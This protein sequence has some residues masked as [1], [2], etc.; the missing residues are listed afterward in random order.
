MKIKGRLWIFPDDNIS[1]DQIFPGKYTYQPLTNEEMAKYSM[2]DYLPEFTKEVQKGDII[3]AGKNFGCGS[4]REQAVT[5]LKFSGVGAIIAPSFARIYYRNAIN[6]AL[7]AIESNEAVTYALEN[8]DK[9][10]MSQVTVDFVEGKI[11]FDDKEFSF[12]KLDAQA[13]EIFKAGG[14]VEYT[15]MKLKKPRRKK[16]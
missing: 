8:K 4:S 12:P 1:T 7:P 11:L 10:S 5:C 3:L 14:L 6:E 15:K 9:L 16:K 2:E 13:A